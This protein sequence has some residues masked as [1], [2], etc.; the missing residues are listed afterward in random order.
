MTVVGRRPHDRT[1]EDGMVSHVLSL[2]VVNVK[3]RRVK[4]SVVVTWR[5]VVDGPLGCCAAG[6]LEK[7][8]DAVIVGGHSGGSRASNRG[9]VGGTKT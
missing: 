8:G 4:R 5:L 1:Q 3:V 2:L 7:S 6:F 9:A